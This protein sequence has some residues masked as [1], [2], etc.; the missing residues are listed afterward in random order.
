MQI[1]Y[2]LFIKI[3]WQISYTLIITLVAMYNTD[4]LIQ[5]IPLSH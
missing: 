4:I 5:S 1:S 2:T 3:N